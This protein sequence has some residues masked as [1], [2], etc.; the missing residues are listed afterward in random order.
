MAGPEIDTRS[1]L[2]KCLVQRRFTVMMAMLGCCFTIIVVLRMVEGA[3][4][5]LGA[6]IWNRHAW[7]EENVMR[8]M[9]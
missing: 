2:V 7:A 1:P 6:E 8:K 4:M 5:E 3:V 9:Y